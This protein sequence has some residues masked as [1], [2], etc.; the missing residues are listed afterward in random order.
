M[1]LSYDVFQ[2]LPKPIPSKVPGFEAEVGQA[3]WPPSTATF[4]WDQDGGLLVDALITRSEA[5][6]LAKWVAGHDGPL[7][8]VYVTHPHADHF[9]G[10]PAVLA[11]FP[12]AR[13][14]ALPDA[15]PA[16]QARV[17]PAAMEVWAGFFPSQLPTEPIVPE[18]LSGNSIPIGDSLA[19]LVAV[20]A[21]DTDNSSVVHVPELRLVVTGD[22]VY[23]RVHMWLAG[24]TPESRASWLR[25][26][27]T[28]ET[29]QPSTIIA[30][31][32]HPDA[33]DDDAH[34]QIEESRQYIAD[35]EDA[36][37]A[38]AG[39]HDLIARMTGRYPDLGNAYTLWVAAFDVLPPT[40]S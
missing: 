27:E 12:A 39:P 31:H 7:S 40:G 28:V 35:F 19:T 1:A 18:P 4:I 20:G 33:P 25:A 21:T 16:L 10:L 29:L 32:R 5:D 2:V 17:S 8:T 38:S 34:R 14:V 3:T 6:L 11:A 36:L 22:V 23:N 13:A 30:G 37:D 15:I 26:L 9:L 24:S